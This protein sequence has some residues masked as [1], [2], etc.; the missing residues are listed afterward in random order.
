LDYW[1]NSLLDYFD[2]ALTVPWI[3]VVVWYVGLDMVGAVRRVW[4]TRHD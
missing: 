4:E 2:V 1:Q 3:V